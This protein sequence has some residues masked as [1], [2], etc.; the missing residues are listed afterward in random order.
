MY[1]KCSKK[2]KMQIPG[3]KFKRFLPLKNWFVCI[4]LKQPFVFKWAQH[5]IPKCS[6]IEIFNLV[7]WFSSSDDKFDLK[8]FQ[9]KL[10]ISFLK[11]SIV[12][13]MD[14]KLGIKPL[15]IKKIMNSAN[16]RKF[17]CWLVVLRKGHYKRLMS[18]KSLYIF[19]RT[20][21]CMIR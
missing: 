1:K 17:W 3:K 13:S 2:R 18:T 21:N 14:W 9:K 19:K 6:V 8:H 4:K 5:F 7:S 15:Q 11:D 16:S 12:I 20:Y 10:R